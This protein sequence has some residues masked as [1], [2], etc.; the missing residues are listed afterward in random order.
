MKTT[1]AELRTALAGAR[2]A[3]ERVLDREHCRISTVLA[4]EIE[5]IF[6]GRF[7]LRPKIAIPEYCVNHEQTRNPCGL[8]PPLE[9]GDDDDD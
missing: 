5:Q 9:F 8:C 4:L 7:Y 3:V 2:G 6:T 1:D